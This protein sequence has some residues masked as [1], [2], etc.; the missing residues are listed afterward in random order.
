MKNGP[1]FFH[2]IGG[3]KKAVGQVAKIASGEGSCYDETVISFAAG[4]I[5]EL[6]AMFRGSPTELYFQHYYNE[7]KRQGNVVFPTL[8]ESNKS[9]SSISG[10]ATSSS[11]S[12]TSSR[13]SRPSS[14]RRSDTARASAHTSLLAHPKDTSL[15]LPSGTSADISGSHRPVDSID[16]LVDFHLRK[17]SKELDEVESV[18]DEVVWMLYCDRKNVLAPALSS[19]LSAVSEAPSASS[20][21]VLGTAFQAKISFLQTCSPRLYALVDRG[22][23]VFGE[24]LLQQCFRT[25]DRAQEA[26]KVASDLQKSR[27][28]RS[29]GYASLLE[30]ASPSMQRKIQQVDAANVLPLDIFDPQGPMPAPASLGG[31][32]GANDVEASLWDVFQ[33]KQDFAPVKVDASHAGSSSSNA[34]K[35]TPDVFSVAPSTDVN[36]CL[37]AP[38]LAQVEDLAD[39]LNSTANKTAESNPFALSPEFASQLNDANNNAQSDRTGT[40]SD[41]RN[42]IARPSHVPSSDSG[43]VAVSGDTLLIA[44][45]Q[46]EDR[47]SLPFAIPSS[48]AAA[49]PEE[50]LPAI[51]FG[52]LSIP[53]MPLPQPV[54]Q[55]ETAPEVEGNPFSE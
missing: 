25:V 15:R 42:S 5:Q 3:S 13:S 34:S 19:S 32:G 55:Q 27:T 39:A 48:S 22:H 52:D 46:G 2:S 35:V 37:G 54:K 17:L 21:S 51:D 40:Q 20:A 43:P 30:Q 33:T 14:S 28:F 12:E 1:D 47:T 24:A 10:V 53:L 50:P 44:A 6:T 7:L 26:L 38:V 23:S 41:D 45:S 31:G 8:D 11:R 49:L 18:V 16:D 4:V 36:V 29:D 9:A